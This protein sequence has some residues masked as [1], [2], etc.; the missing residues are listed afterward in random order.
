MK[1]ML[2][3][4]LC[5]MLIL[6]ACGAATAD[7][8][9][10]IVTTQGRRIRGAIR[11]QP[12][13]KVYNV[14]QAN[15][16]TL[17]VPLADVEKVTVQQPAQI[18]PAVKLVQAGR[19]AQAMPV[20]EEIIREYSMLQ[21]DAVAA[22]WLAEAHLQQGNPGDA[23]KYCELVIDQNPDA[24][25]FGEL[26]RIYW[27][28]LLEA[29]REATLKQALTEAVQRGSRETAALAQ[30]LRGD[31]AMKNEN[32]REALLDG[33]LRTVTL[34]REIK[35]V[36]PEALYKAAKCFEEL[37]QLA[38]SEKMRKK[39]LEEYPDDPYTEKIKSGA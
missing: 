28:A 9:G 27:K 13:S 37:G 11:W 21:W 10:E 36:Q 30:V 1:H 12:A 23:V 15:N 32:Y 38:H 33:Y 4:M 6:L 19:Y 8:P 18:E 24:G 29:G 3:N 7:V 14:V 22:R 25:V 17:K 26:P 31:I 34:F 39:L 35:A 2:R 5:S 20:L 16:V